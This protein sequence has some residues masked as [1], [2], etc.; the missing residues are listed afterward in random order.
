MPLPP[1]T[2]RIAGAAGTAWRHRAGRPAHRVPTRCA[3]EGTQQRPR[4]RR[5]GVCGQLLPH[6]RDR[7]DAADWPP[8]WRRRRAHQ[9]PAAQSRQRA[10]T[11]GGAARGGERRPPGAGGGRVRR[12]SGR[13]RRTVAADCASAGVQVVPRDGEVA[14]P[15]GIRGSAAAVSIGLRGRFPGRG[16]PGW[17]WV[18]IPSVTDPDRSSPAW[19]KEHHDDAATW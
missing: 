5:T 6:R 16:D 13:R 14:R 12:R 17:F 18:E 8:A 4:A 2:W 15:G 7:G 11:M 19:R 3:A 1:S 10:E 9:R